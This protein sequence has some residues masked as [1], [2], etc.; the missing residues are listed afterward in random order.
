MDLLRDTGAFPCSVCRSGVGVNSIQCS[1]CKLWVHKKCSAIKGRLV[2]IPDY[3][4]PRCRG[5]ARPIDGRPVTQVDVDGT[6][7]D[8]EASFCYL[9]DMLCSG[10]GCELAIIT[11]CRNAW[12][13]FKK[14]LPILTSKHVSLKTRGKLFNTCVRSAMLY[15]RET[16]APTVSDLQRM[17]R[18][19]RSMIRWICGVK[20]IDEVPTETLHAKLGILEVTKALCTKRLRWFGH[21][22]R[23]SSGINDILDFSPPGSRR[24]G[25]PAGQK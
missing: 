16:W 11:R 8:V 19:D 24:R 7:L 23:A 3:V 15:G 10:G 17:R 2:A 4:C 22:S 20:P 21:V 1:I 9:G 12:G 5:H 6:L 18:N 14:L 25:R 13:K